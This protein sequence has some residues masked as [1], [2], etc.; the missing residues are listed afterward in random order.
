[1][2]TQIPEIKEYFVMMEMDKSPHTVASYERSVDKF[3]SFLNIQTLQDLEV[4]TPLDCR[5]FQAKLKETL[6][7]SSVNANVR[8]LKALFNWL[9]EQEYLESSPF[10]KVK[11]LKEGKKIPV[12]LSEEETH[13]MINA[14]QN[15]LDKMLVVLFISTGLRRNEIAGLKLD[16][17]KECSIYVAG[18]GSKER[19]VFLQDDVC[20]LLKQYLATRNRKP[21]NRNSEYLFVSR[22]GK[23]FTGSGILYKIKQI[24]LQAGIPEERASAISPHS[25]RHTFTANMIE[26]G[27]DIRVIQGAL[28]H[29]SLSTTER[30]AHLRNSALQSAMRNQK[31]IL[32]D[33]NE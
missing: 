14:C 8:P 23:N 10:N 27:A 6:T 9:V 24:A 13:A 28:G 25:L 18:K 17:L 4:V 1:M 20:E 33:I 7:K 11:A 16:Q 19:E 31:S 30:Y 3:F 29:S 32:G 15:L 22:N 21:R 26:S 2:E 12:F 5:N